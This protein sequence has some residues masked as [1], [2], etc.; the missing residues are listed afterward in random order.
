MTLLQTVPQDLL[1]LEL[2]PVM[3]LAL[4]RN[5]FLSESA[6]HSGVRVRGFSGP[7]NKQI[8]IFHCDSYRLGTIFFKGH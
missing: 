4:C 8:E 3:G 1:Y 6:L 2:I 7:T 5:R